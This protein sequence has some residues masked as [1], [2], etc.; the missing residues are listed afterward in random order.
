MF[1]VLLSLYLDY[2]IT[3]LGV[4]VNSFFLFFD[5]IIYK[6]KLLFNYYFS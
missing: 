2:I 6:H 4:Y 5:K 1:F 3:L